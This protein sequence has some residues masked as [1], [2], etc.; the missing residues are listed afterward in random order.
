MSDTTR[1]RGS[2]TVAFADPISEDLP[3][4]K[5]WD[6]IDAANRQ[7]ILYRIDKRRAK[8]RE[9]ER[10]AAASTEGTGGNATTDTSASTTT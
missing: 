9:A 10:L 7:K 3:P 1:T 8:R 4:G 6:A 5:N 2:L